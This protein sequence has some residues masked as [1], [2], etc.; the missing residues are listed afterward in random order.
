MTVTKEDLD[1]LVNYRREEGAVSFYLY[2]SP[3][4][5]FPEFHSRLNSF[6]DFIGRKTRQDGR[7]LR[8]KADFFTCVEKELTHYFPGDK[9]RTFCLFWSP[10]IYYYLEVPVRLREMAVV[11]P[12]FHTRPLLNALTQFERYAVLVFDR[13]T[14]RLF[15]YY[16]GRM[17]EESALFG[18]YVL[19]NFNPS[20]GSF[21]SRREKTTARK[22]QES[23]YRHLREAARLTFDN[24]DRYGFQKLLLGSHVDEVNMIKRFLHP[25]LTERLA[26]QFISD[27]DD[28]EKI[29][30]AK[31]VE[32]VSDHRR[33][34]EREKIQML[35]DA[36][37]HRRAVLGVEKVDEALNA[38]KVSELVINSNFHQEGYYCPQRH[39]INARP[40]DNRCG[41]CG[42]E[43]L[44]EPNLEDEI[45]EESWL[46]GSRIFNVIEEQEKFSDDQIG[47][48]LRY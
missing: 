3:R 20:A 12:D 46:K 44:R 38:D 1:I 18:D 43:L 23:Y 10:E 31:I 39:Y 37:A 9:H 40:A 28:P 36:S 21:Q 8:L 26:G 29:I 13:R 25:Y 2:S 47:A 17:R 22:I 14:V 6:V 34:V 27:P 7:E 24:F 41:I 33:R 15:Q 5:T 42:R 48:F 16:M 45:V 30:E 35:I 4:E 11:G 32:C 19:P